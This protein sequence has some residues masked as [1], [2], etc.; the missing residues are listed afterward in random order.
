MKLQKLKRLQNQQNN[1]KIKKKYFA[2]SISFFE[3]Y[4]H[5]NPMGIGGY[6][7]QTESSFST[8]Q[9]DF[10]VSSK[11]SRRTSSLSSG[12]LNVKFKHSP[13]S[14]YL[15]VQF[16]ELPILNL[17]AKALKYSMVGAMTPKVTFRSSLIN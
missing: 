10:S 13:I 8:I 3:V 9:F 4:S 12:G 11:K 1:N 6:V 7:R 16:I 2:G 14:L 15:M 5:R 17:E